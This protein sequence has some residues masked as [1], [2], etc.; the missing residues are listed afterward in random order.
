MN[1]T[2]AKTLSTNALALRASAMIAELN[3]RRKVALGVFV[4]NADKWPGG[5]FKVTTDEPDDWSTFHLFKAMAGFDE[6]M[7]ESFETH[8]AD[9]GVTMDGDK[10]GDDGEPLI[11]DTHDMDGYHDYMGSR[12]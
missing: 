3:K 10:L 9:M 1:A 4:A 2:E 8:C 6:S 5:T 12:I 11:G 7:L